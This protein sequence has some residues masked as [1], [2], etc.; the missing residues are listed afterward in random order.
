[1]S[2]YYLAQ[3]NQPNSKNEKSIIYSGYFIGFYIGVL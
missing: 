3:S 2:L 1:M